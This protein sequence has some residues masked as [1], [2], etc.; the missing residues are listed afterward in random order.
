MY[1]Y[2]R[3]LV[4]AA[5]PTPAYARHATHANAARAAGGFGGFSVA[6][7]PGCHLP[8]VQDT[9]SH[10]GSCASGSSG[11][12][13]SLSARPHAAA[14]ARQAQHKIV[15]AESPLATPL[16]GRERATLG[17]GGARGAGASL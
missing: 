8:C 16:L 17:G 5:T 2:A 15:V 10:V 9:P 14:H 1:S 6:E 12:G 13:G 7:T 3:A 4:V 11:G